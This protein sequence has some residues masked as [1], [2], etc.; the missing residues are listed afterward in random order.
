MFFFQDLT[1]RSKPWEISWLLNGIHGPIP[2]VLLTCTFHKGNQTTGVSQQWIILKISLYLCHL[3]HNHPKD[4]KIIT[5]NW[6]WI[7]RVINCVKKDSLSQ[8]FTFREYIHRSIFWKKLAKP[9]IQWDAS[10]TTLYSHTLLIPHPIYAH[11]V[12]PHWALA[13]L[14]TVL[15]NWTGK[16]C[17]AF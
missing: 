9:P 7:H 12:M 14:V 2:C 5:N 11:W 3:S 6:K 4:H 13:V 17:N 8:M 15:T 16:N 10:K 1:D